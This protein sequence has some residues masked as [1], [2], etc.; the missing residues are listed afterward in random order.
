MI[1]RGKTCVLLEPVSQLLNARIP[2][3]QRCLD[4]QHVQNMVEDQAQEY[5]THGCFSMVQSFTIGELGDE[6]FILDGQHRTA[7]YTKLQEHGFPVHEAIVPVVLYKATSRDELSE[8]YNRINKHMPIHPFEKDAVWEDVGKEF[9]QLFQHHFGP[10]VKPSRSCRCPHISLDELKTHLHARNISHRL[11]VRD[12]WS[13]VE[14]L[15]AYMGTKVQDQMCP[16]IRKRLNE[17]AAKA[18]KV[19]CKPCFLGAWRRFEWIDIALY[20]LEHPDK[21]VEMSVFSQTAA[22]R[23]R[24]PAAL[25]EQ[26]WKRHTTNVCDTGSCFVCERALLFADM[27]CGHIVAHALGGTSTLDN[28][29]PIC[30]TCNRD[31]G[32]MNLMQYRAM[33]GTGI[34]DID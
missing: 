18:A 24:I 29:M 9:C 5:R 20:K 31:M 6:R 19:N 12:M 17:C 27:E 25:R 16:T 13:T 32:I 22:T 23:A 30:K 34:M 15:N 28:L 2:R 7:A 11:S 26:V 10:Y 1:E 8:Y 21:P 14:E 3:L 33:L 4:E